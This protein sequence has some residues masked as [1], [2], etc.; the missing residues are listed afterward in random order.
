VAYTASIDWQVTP[1]ILLYARTSN[2]FKSGGLPH[3]VSLDPQTSDP[4]LPES[5]TDYEIGFKS[6][7]WDNRV[8]LNIAAYYSDYTNIQRTV[9]T[10]GFSP[11]SPPTT[12]TKNAASARIQG[13][14]VELSTRPVDGL[15]LGGTVSYTDARYR[16]FLSLGVDQSGQL[17]QNVPK[18]TYS[19]SAAYTVPLGFADLRA[20]A[21]WYWRGRVDMFPAGGAPNPDRFQESYG[22]LSGR[23]SLEL[24]EPNIEIAL[25]G[26]NLT[27]EVYFNAAFD[28]FA[29]AGTINQ[30]IAEPRTYGLEAIFR[31]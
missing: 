6:R 2:G 14:E 7:F 20:Q 31:F 18:W 30:Y 15:E 27:D 22:L 13:F 8:R 28:N 17:F 23:L 3:R 5:V 24:H 26:R 16:Q 25:W 11:G 21:N 10:P 29:T 1:L 12:A 4:F 19:L 9:L